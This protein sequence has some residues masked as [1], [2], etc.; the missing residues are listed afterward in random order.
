VRN[1]LIEMQDLIF[2]AQQALGEADEE[3]RQ[4]RRQLDDREALKAIEADLAFQPE[5][6]WL[7]RKSD[8][9]KCCAACWGEQKKVAPLVPM[10]NGYYE[11]PIH[12]STHQ[13]KEAKEA[14]ERRI[15]RPAPRLFKG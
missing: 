12:K 4:L 9:A 11:C 1:R 5:E 15:Q 14:R 7:L 10:M 8:G 2:S 6:G 3:N 13:T